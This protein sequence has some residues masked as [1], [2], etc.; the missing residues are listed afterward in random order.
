MQSEQFEL[1]ADIEQRH[2]WFVARRRILKALVAEVLPQSP[3]TVV[4]DVGCG[5][6]ANIAALADQYRCVGIDTS[7]DAIEFARQRF[8]D[9]QFRQGFAPEDLGE[10]ASQAGLF[11]LTDVLEHVP[12]DFAL[13]SKLLAAAK[14]GAY[15]LITVPADLSLWSEHDESF[16]HYRRYD[17]ARLKQVWKGLAVTPLLTSY[18]NSRLCPI[19]RMSR[20]ASRR[21]GKAGGQAGTDFWMPSAPANWALTTI[22]SGESRR[23]LKVIRD[24]SGGFRSGVSLVAMLRRE[25]GPIEVRNK[26][27]NI[28]PDFFDP[29]S[30][31]HL[32]EIAPVVGGD[33][34]AD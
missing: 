29:V 17:E 5:T 19:V 25:D 18:Y 3:E 9:V 20:A 6:G 28:A 21:R 15:F 23:L 1:H 24:Q 22:F 30:Q 2:W 8:P 14:P 16:G 27:A 33:S 12:D 26:P 34:L 7:T 32:T 13:L 4:V 11:L 31:R 10:I